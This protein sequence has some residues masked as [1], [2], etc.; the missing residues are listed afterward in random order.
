MRTTCGLI[1]AAVVAG[2]GLVNA[3]NGAE[4]GAKCVVV[5]GDATCKVPARLLA[6]VKE[7]Q[8]SMA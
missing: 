1:L 7:L 5:N 6:Q 3:A 8:M 4:L 2:A